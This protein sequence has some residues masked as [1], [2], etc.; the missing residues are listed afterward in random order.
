M[1]RN[2]VFGRS[3]GGFEGGDG[4]RMASYGD[5]LIRKFTVFYRVLIL[6]SRDKLPPHLEITFEQVEI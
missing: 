6:K 3:V 5:F 2:Q 4:R 1:I